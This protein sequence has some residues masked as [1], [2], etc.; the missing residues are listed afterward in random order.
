MPFLHSPASSL[1]SARA[2]DDLFAPSVAQVFEDYG[3]ALPSLSAFCLRHATFNGFASRKSLLGSIYL[4][5]GAA[6][7]RAPGLP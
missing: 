2:I 7:R 1:A 3:Y 5:Y 6:I 4:F